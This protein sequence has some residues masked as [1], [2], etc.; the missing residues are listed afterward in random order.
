MLKEIFLT[1]VFLSYSLVVLYFGHV[2]ISGA[3]EEMTRKIWVLFRLY[4]YSWPLCDG[5]LVI[6]LFTEG[7]N[8]IIRMT[9]VL[10]CLSCHLRDTGLL[11]GLEQ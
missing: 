8:S 5:L 1:K 4:L 2:R 6:S 11:M 9:G 3:R 7:N 10:V